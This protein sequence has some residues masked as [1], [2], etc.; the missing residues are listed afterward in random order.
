MLA[1]ACSLVPPCKHP[2]LI[3]II[4][5]NCSS[6]SMLVCCRCWACSCMGS[7]STGRTWS[8]AS[9]RHRHASS[10]WTPRW[11]SQGEARGGRGC[12]SA[13]G[14]TNSSASQLKG[15]FSTPQQAHTHTHTAQHSTAHTAQHTAHTVSHS[16][17]LTPPHI[18]CHTHTHTARVYVCVP[19]GQ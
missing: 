19:R 9:S 8:A 3:V 16:V 18:Q 6:A 11:M 15:H 12:G 10:R 4:L 17:T 13:H 2:C 5:A 14:V 7:S 1:V